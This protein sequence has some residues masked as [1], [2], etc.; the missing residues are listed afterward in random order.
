[1]I[2]DETEFQISLN[3]PRLLDRIEALATIGAVSGGGVS[4]V[5]FTEEDLA[6][7]QQVNRWMN[8]AGMVTRIDAAGNLIGRYDGLN[9]TLPAL[10][11]GSH[12]DT[13]TRGG[14]YDGCLGVLAGLELVET[15][16]DRQHR[17]QHPIEVIVFT[18]EESTVI[19]SKAMA[20]Q[21]PLQAPDVRLKNNRLL[22][23]CLQSIGGDWDRIQNA[24]R[25]ETEIAAFIELHVEQGGE[26]ERY[27]CAIGIV[28]GIVGQYRY[29]LTIDGQANHAGTTP[30]DNRQ[31]S[32]VAAAQ[33]ILAVQATVQRISSEAVGTVG[34]LSNYPNV[35]NTISGRV[36][37]SIDLRDLDA[38]RLSHVIEFLTMQFDRIAQSTRTT[39][40]LE[41][42]LH[43]APTI[44]SGEII[45]S[46]EQICD[47]RNLSYRR[48]PSRAGHDAQEIG[49]VTKMGMIFV[50]SRGGISHDH[51]EYTAPEACIQGA[52]VLLD[53]FRAIDS[54][55]D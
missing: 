21:I 46:L 39:F 17:L 11:T 50:P 28:T 5:A 9:P 40:C 23:D 42:T 15:L 10:A 1:M 52:I 19:G 45:Q 13:V 41:E 49:R 2:V 6:A 29:R 27:G 47:R 18:D 22:S 14:K 26:L 34:Y 8:A 43:I 48:L 44:A 25:N 51:T 30:M 3:G 31:D 54:S 53:I 35:T 38:D 36:E 20:G 4:R 7:R 33:V 12:I 32:L 24:T 37:L 16:S 55:K